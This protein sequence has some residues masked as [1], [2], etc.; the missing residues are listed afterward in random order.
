MDLTPGER[1]VLMQV[2]ELFRQA[3]VRAYA[4]DQLASRWPPAHTKAF[5][6]GYEGL[7][8]RG[9]LVQSGKLFGISS[10]GLKLMT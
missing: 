10:T 4:V 9:L 3:S 8:R 1:A 6:A 2:R 5:R 7:V